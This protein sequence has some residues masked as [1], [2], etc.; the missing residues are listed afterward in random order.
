MQEVDDGR[1]AEADD[2]MTKKLRRAFKIFD[3]NGDGKIDK[4]ELK[5]LLSRM[6]NQ[7]TRSL[8]DADVQELINDF[9]D[10]GDGVLEINEIINA[11]RFITN[12]DNVDETLA[13]QRKQAAA[14]MAGRVS[15]VD[16]DGR[17]T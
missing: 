13:A 8:S 1:P 9:D 5:A 16:A 4:G 17:A 3:K 14:K 6:G 12:E 11:W 10:N 15:K 2:E 7:D